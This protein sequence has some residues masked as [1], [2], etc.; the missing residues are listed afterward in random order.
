M[1]TVF[2]SCKTE[3]VGQPKYEEIQH[4]LDVLLS[5]LDVLLSALDVLLSALDV[6]LSALD[7][8]LSAAMF[9]AEFGDELRKDTLSYSKLYDR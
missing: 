3:P 6:L 8:L 5:A 9:S 2:L 4:A 7:V 1:I